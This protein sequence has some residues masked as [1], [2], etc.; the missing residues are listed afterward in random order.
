MKFVFKR[1]FWALLTLYVALLL[2]IVTV[3][4]N[5]LNDYSK[6][7]N[8][9]LG[10]KGYR[11][12]TVVTE[13]EDLEY[14]KSAYVQYDEDGNVMYTIDENGYLHQVYDDVALRNAAIEKAMQVQREG[15]VV[16]WNSES[17]GLPL[18]TGSA[19][20]L[21]SHSSVDWGYSG[22]G[23]GAA[24]K[25]DNMKVALEKAGLS[26]NSTLWNFYSKGAGKDYVRT[27]MIE[28]NE[29]PWEVY[30]DEVK[31]S[32]ASY[33]DAAIIVLTR[34]TR[35][36]SIGG[37][38]ADVA[39]TGADTP[40]GDYLDLS[41]EEERMIDE[42]VELKKAGT[43]DKVIVLLNTP[44]GI[45]MD[46]L[47]ERRGDID[48]CMW[49]GQT[50]YC[51]LNEVGNILAGNSIPS[52]HL[53]DTFAYNT[54]S[55]PAYANT[56]ATMYTNAD[57]M[58]LTSID[59]QGVYL[60][61][62]EGIY[63]GYKYYETRY[64]DAVLG[65]GNATS[66]PGAVNSSSDWVYG[67][68]V[69]F[70]FGYSAGYT[71][72]E[73]SNYSVSE[74]EDGDYVVTLTVRNI[75]SAVGADAVQIYVQ[76]P[77]TEYD[78]T[79]GIE[80]ASV[81]L[82]GFVKTSELNPGESEEVSVTVRADAFKT[83][84]AYNKKTYIRE[85]GDYYITAAQDAHQAVNNILA[86]KGYT[87]ENTDGVMDASGDA[88]LA[89]KFSFAEDDFETF[90]VSEATGNSIT[91]RFD[92]VDWNLYEN[93]GPETITYLSRSNW[94]DTYPTET[95]KL[96]LT[97]KMV[98]DLAY[99]HEAAV[100]PDDK[101][102]LYEQSHVFNLIDL[103][104]I[105][106][107]SE[108]W[109]TLLNQLSIDEQIELLGSAYFGTIAID[110]IAK[111]AE[112]AVNGPLGVKSKYL[113]SGKSTMS[114]PS[115]T[116][117]AASYNEKLAKEVGE[118]MGEDALHSGATGIYAPGANTHRTAYS[119]RNWEYLSED[120]FL[121]GIIAKNEVIGMQSKGCYVTMKHFALNDQESYRHGVSVWC[122][123]QA[124]RE[125]YLA[126]YEYAVTEG[127]ATGMMS[128]FN[129]FGTKWSGAH[130]GLCTDMLRGEWGLK[131]FVLS[132]SAWQSYM[133][134][135]DGVMAGND[136]ILYNVDLAH[137]NSA[138]TN[139]TVAKAVREST[140]RILYVIANSNA[141]NGINSSTKIIEVKE[142]WQELVIDM[143]TALKIATVILLI[144]TILAFLI[145]RRDDL[146]FG[147]NVAV[148]VITTSIT[149]ILASV[150]GVSSVVV[151]RVLKNLPEDYIGNIFVSIEGD[152][153]FDNVGEKEPSLKD[154]LEGDL[155]TYKF[156]A[157]CSELTSDVAKAGTEDKGE[158]VTNYPSGGMFISGMKNATEFK[159]VFKITSEADAPA[160]LSLSMGLRDWEM[161]L[162][163]V[164][165]LT[166][167]GEVIEIGEDVVFPVS[168]G[169]K[170]WDW[171]ELEI[172]II[173][174]KQGENTITL[175][176]KAGLGD[177]A[178]YGLNFDYLAL[179]S[180]TKAEW[181]HEVGVGHSYG[182]W[183]L[184]S[185][186]TADKAG[187]IRTTCSTC[188]DRQ[189]R[190]LPVISDANG[191]SKT[192]QSVNGIYTITSWS[193]TVEGY[194]YTTK[195][196]EYPDGWNDYKFEAE[197]SVLTSDAGKITNE[198]ISSTAAHYPSGGLFIGNMKNAS[199]FKTVFNI[200][201]DSN[202][203]AILSLCLGLRDWTFTPADI[204]TL[205]VN[206]EE[207]EI[208]SGVV[209]PVYTGVK[210]FDWTCLEIAPIQL[211]AGNN[212]II[213]EK[214]AGLG[215]DVG[216]GLNFDYLSI[217]SVATLQWTSEVG[218]GHSYNEW[219][220][221]TEPTLYSEGLV[222]SYC[223]TCRDYIEDTIP[224]ISEENGYV[225]TSVDSVVYGSATWELIKGESTLSFVTRNYPE[226]A[227]KYIFEAESATI[228]GDA[229]MYYSATSGASNN[230][231]LYNL[232]NGNW[233]VTFEIG[234]DKECKALLIMRFSCDSAVEFANGRTLT[235]NGKHI[236]LS[237]LTLE[238]SS[239]KWK[240]Y[241]M[242]IIDLEMGKNVITLSNDGSAF[243]KN[244][245]YLALYSESN[246]S[247]YKGDAA[248]TC[249]P[250]AGQAVEPGCI[251]PGATAGLYCSICYNV[252]EEQEEIEPLGHIDEDADELCDRCTAIVCA[253]HAVVTDAY[254]APTCT[255][256]GLTE[257][258]HCSVCGEILV[259]QNSI[260][261][262]GHKDENGDNV[263]DNAPHAVVDNDAIV[264]L[265]PFNIQNGKNPFDVKNAGD[266]GGL[267][268]TTHTSYGSF[269]EKSPG[270][271]FTVTIIASKA[272]NVDFYLTAV[273]N[274]AGVTTATITEITLN[275][276]T[277]GVTIADVTA[278]PQSA[279][280]SVENANNVRI[281]TLAL[282]EGTNVITF[283]RDTG[284]ATYNDQQNN[285]NITGIA[286]SAP[287][288]VTL[289]SNEYRFTV[290]ANNP[291]AEANGG[292][293]DGLSI[294]NNATYG[295][296]Y[297]QSF[298]K[299]FTV[300]INVSKATTVEFYLLTTTRFSGITTTGSVAD[301]KLN[302]STEGVTR[303]EGD[304][305]NIGGWNTSAATCE[306]F[307]TLELQ[308]GTN[309]I[310]FTRVD[311]NPDDANDQN[312]NLAGVS[313]TSDGVEIKLGPA[314]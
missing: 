232:N 160:V 250:V 66:A 144:I 13:G 71:S 108:H 99:D 25:G 241:E 102:P 2:V 26:V 211:N 297:E 263:C 130:K 294:V 201:S 223:A 137:Y 148:K 271:T 212:E 134:I 218:V 28:M 255:E 310:T 188:R 52:G 204:L 289:G 6:V 213:I 257:G 111:P 248:H 58:G 87:P 254:K 206:G 175:E 288:S 216:N 11:M 233:S 93:K 166:V 132:D 112:V 186:P 133:G 235:V 73:Y 18:G 284:D 51:G 36:G 205:T 150:V 300:T 269:Y 220:V 202:T 165:T 64:E 309:V 68:E 94:R 76:K 37:A 196:V 29:V 172:A 199:N 210:H 312:F 238:K 156:E 5:I 95:V 85:K 120:S 267:S 295:K 226:N 46:S 281:A 198:S 229:K 183:E 136:C 103:M 114:Y 180:A 195:T 239:A 273:T 256:D 74:N 55:A 89:R 109:D 298:G 217:G 245:D 56:I 190:E 306:H 62:A 131:G 303:I 252:F 214:K 283:T 162:A 123:E 262:I 110:S 65:R 251:E 171:Y 7:I 228:S 187:Q 151:P 84:D 311:K 135:I 38:S 287:A 34:L 100:N 236:S 200:T 286:V 302:G 163:N 261:A 246:L 224:E 14:F 260:D 88:N 305:T 61:Y 35:E 270:V 181:T 167:N 30:T 43:F 107:D 86:A 189:T 60:A 67:E 203:T 126:A 258:S 92:D 299:T 197:C 304:V 147:G 209:Y 42:V 69:A 41:N 90:S 106:Y 152:G 179:T 247:K 143:Q 222:Y 173:N 314:E 63:I 10:L 192:E 185:E 272:M 39:Q 3:A 313:F 125:V 243:V 207:V 83:Y 22:G 105:D 157:E 8:N 33:G 16:L 225:K 161:V 122:N 91:N 96:S 153:G 193:I 208:D 48:C 101:M 146:D 79:Y 168:H 242:V 75:G 149:V 23:S 249:N 141:M 140:H 138:K 276:S 158:V 227:E 240:E 21:F 78:K 290:A 234:S 17:N 253:T 159:T 12:Q 54:T 296:Y 274:R 119:S 70:P 194:T 142:W 279:S 277:T 215:N 20:S 184:V 285:Y 80:Q 139:P 118:L 264:E 128:A 237:G 115:P 104:G 268:V 231:Y 301:I 98:G 145:I 32:F 244:F 40:T 27:G 31:N 72:F 53:A 177:G 278:I 9:A 176:K 4:G 19:V 282:K 116:I 291:F 57:S 169:V 170:Y 221:I 127:H 113:D 191:Y 259:K 129:R 49:V 178:G 47:V 124:L 265:Y 307:A 121:S 275:G 266:A 292:D 174:L 44:A 155:V 219:K 97:D 164:V 82:A 117:L 230:Y 182:A 59:R 45:Y 280:W 308:A 81:N 24:T 293:A 15:T 77:Y 154:Q 50:G 1:S